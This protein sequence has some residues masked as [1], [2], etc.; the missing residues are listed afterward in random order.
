MYIYIFVYL[1][2]HTKYLHIKLI[3]I[4]M[5]TYVLYHI[6]NSVLVWAWNLRSWKLRTTVQKLEGQDRF[7]KESTQ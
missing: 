4:C 1:F 6:I 7:A 2:M 3:Q 5:W